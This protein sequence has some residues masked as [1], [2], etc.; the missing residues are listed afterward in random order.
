MWRSHSFSCDGFATHDADGV[1][2]NP[3]LEDCM[4]TKPPAK[5]D[6]SKRRTGVKVAM[7]AAETKFVRNGDTATPE[8][9]DPRWN[10][11]GSTRIVA[12]ADGDTP[13]DFT[14]ISPSRVLGKNLLQLG[15]FQL[16]KK[17]G[18]GAMGAVY[19]AKQVSFNNR[20]V[21]LKVLF[22][23]VSKIPKL[24]ERLRRE[25]Q[26]MGQLDHRNIIQAY[27][28][29]EAEGCHFVA[30][31]YVPGQNTQKWLNQVKRFPVADAVRIVLD[32]AKALAYAH[33]QGVVHRD[34]K[35]ENI[36]LTKSGAVKVADLGM[37]KLN[38]ED[39]SL[40]QTGHAVGTPWYMPLE[41]ARNAKDIDG[42]SDI[43]ALGCTLYAF[44]TGQPPF[45]G[46]T[47]VEVLK[48]KEAGSFMP[49]RQANSD[50]TERLDLIILKMTAKLPKY[51]YQS[52]DELVADL[53]SLDLAAKTISFVSQSGVT[54]KREGDSDELAKTNIIAG[55]VAK[56]RVDVDFAKSAGIV[57]DPN[58]WYIQNTNASGT[59][60]TTRY[61]TAQ[62]R[63]MLAD[64]VIK[65]TVR[66]SQNPEEGF[67]ALATFKEFQGAAMS[68]MTKK[69][70]DQNTARYQGIYKRIKEGERKKEAEEKDEDKDTALRVNTRYW[71]GILVTVL[72]AAVVLVGLFLVLWWLFR[73]TG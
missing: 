52:C 66:A 7:P 61:T 23:H 32:C 67:R 71:F 60:T 38:D 56:S 45:V 11:L 1:H 35:P 5:L 64:G 25:G 14:E 33:E 36:L 44:L 26:V 50:V 47:I 51:R 9:N 24:V 22:P 48:A 62:L 69:V 43:Y 27:A 49:A 29:G 70:A 42:R 21:A 59:I 54:I 20:V 55:P 34:I 2:V 3:L 65:P 16:I 30:M 63:K 39:M 12:G 18:E 13:S 46:R 10:E 8:E 6:S 68:K 41:Q 40:T 53:E 58:T 4:G 37:V 31:E 72:P 57:L 28:V 73:S 15:D 17:L 19:K